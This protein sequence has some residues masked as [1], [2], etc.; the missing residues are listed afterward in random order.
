MASRF[1]A[2]GDS[3]KQTEGKRSAPDGNC[4]APPE[5]SRL[6]RPQLPPL[7]TRS[8]DGPGSIRE[9]KS[10]SP[11]KPHFYSPKYPPALGF[12]KGETPSK[13]VSLLRLAFTSRRAV[14][15]LIHTHLHLRCPTRP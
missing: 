15:A 11:L 8:V 4:S 14:F 5:G 1:P 3:L 2:R 7:G 12:R 13:N 9:Q 10:F 6:K